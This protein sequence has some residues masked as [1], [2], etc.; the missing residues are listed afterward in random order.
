MDRPNDQLAVILGMLAGFVLIGVVVTRNVPEISAAARDGELLFAE[1]CSACHGEGAVG[2]Y[3]PG[4]DLAARDS[5]ESMSDDELRAFF[6]SSHPRGGFPKPYV[7]PSAAEIARLVSY[8][9]VLGRLR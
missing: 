4:K 1:R 8:L 5:L 7:V 3:N 9:R 6:E 2:T